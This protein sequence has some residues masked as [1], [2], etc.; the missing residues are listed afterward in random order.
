MTQPPAP[1]TGPSGSN[2]RTAIGAIITVIVAAI[3]GT[4]FLITQ[5]HPT[6]TSPDT[7]KPAATQ[8]ASAN[9][10]TV[11]VETL[12]SKTDQSTKPKPPPPDP[13]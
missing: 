8:P 9:E 4:A 3:G 7:Q 1:A 2:A 11:P 5:E 10:R 13:G 6:P 12:P